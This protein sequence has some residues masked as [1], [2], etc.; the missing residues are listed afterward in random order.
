MQVATIERAQQ[1]A[2]AGMRSEWQR[3]LGNLREDLVARRHLMSAQ[4]QCQLFRM[5]IAGALGYAA[6]VLGVGGALQASLSW[7]LCDCYR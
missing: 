4:V 3:E 6:A 2:L 1:A 7:Q 5:P